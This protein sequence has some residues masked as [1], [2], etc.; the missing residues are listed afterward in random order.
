MRKT[1]LVKIKAWA[2]RYSQWYADTQEE[3]TEITGG[4]SHNP[5]CLLHVVLQGEED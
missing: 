4:T 1:I 2:D 5:T 3:W